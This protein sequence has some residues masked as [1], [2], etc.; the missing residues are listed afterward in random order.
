MRHRLSRR[1]HIHVCRQLG[2]HRAMTCSHR[3]LVAP[4][5]SMETVSCRCEWPCIYGCNECRPAPHRTVLG[6][7]C[8]CVVV[9]PETVCLP[10]TFALPETV[11][12]PE[13]V[14]L[15]EMVLGL[16]AVIDHLEPFCRYSHGHLS[17][18]C[19]ASDNCVARFCF[20][21]V[22]SANVIGCGPDHV[23]EPAR[24]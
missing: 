9:L 14:F 2:G 10:P 23:H 6:F 16:S 5:C 13:T 1:Y 17:L 19:E 22:R 4:G 7:G 18:C 11:L 20:V 21:L 8:S 15:S 24:I 3:L 12:F